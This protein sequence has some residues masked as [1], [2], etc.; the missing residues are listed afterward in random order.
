MGGWGEKGNGLTGRRE[1]YG[2]GIGEERG[3]SGKAGKGVMSFISKHNIPSTLLMWVNG[4]RRMRIRE[5]RERN[6]RI[7]L[8]MQIL[9][10]VERSGT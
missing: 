1:T 10:G 3:G 4:L 9:G 7:L 6:S 5:D 2:A 8:T